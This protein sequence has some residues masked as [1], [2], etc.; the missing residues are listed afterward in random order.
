MLGLPGGV[1]KGLKAEDLPKF[2]QL[3]Q[4]GLEFALWTL[5]VFKQIVLANPDYVKLITSRRLHPQ[6][7]LH[8]H[9]GRAEQGQLLRRQASR[10]G[11]RRQGSLQVRPRSSTST[12]WPSTSSRGAT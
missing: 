6:D 12:T 1:S 5:D 4:D 10:R 7:L 3:A 2:K 11:L 8:G 9:G